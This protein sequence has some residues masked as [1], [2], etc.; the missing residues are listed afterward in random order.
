MRRPLDRS[1][2][3]PVATLKEYFAKDFN[4][5]LNVA[6]EHKATI[7]DVDEPIL[8]PV[9][10]HLDFDGSAKFVSIY[11]PSG[12]DPVGLTKFY[13]EDISH[14]LK[15]AVSVGV[16]TGYGK[17]GF[18]ASSE[19]L[20]FTGRLF[21]YSED[22]LDNATL[23]QLHEYCSSSGIKL[24][25]RS[26]GYRDERNRHERPQAFI[27]HDSRDKKEV[28]EPIA[29]G[30]QK[31]MCPVW[32]D[33]FSLRVGASLRES[34]EKGIKE[35]ET[36]I[37]ILSPHFFSN[38]G[39]SKAE[40]DSIYSREI[41]E[42]KRVILPVWHGVSKEDVYNYCPMLVDRFGVTTELGID[43]VVRRLHVA[44]ESHGLENAT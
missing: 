44:I 30:L 15:I 25:F 23:L 12:I 22:A 5:L 29:V 43:E 38:D 42:K 13:V 18:H 7:R 14:A 20:V 3:R 8:Y 11:V 6:T 21:V 34:I 24:V 35:A 10:V 2:G 36:C 1:K 27:A 40:F 9:R 31:R 19:D 26:S 37:V 33:E 16:A 4:R 41:I 32:Y 17:L 39:W 28:A